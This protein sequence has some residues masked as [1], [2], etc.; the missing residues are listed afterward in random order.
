M[1]HE[2]RRVPDPFCLDRINECLRSGSRSIKLRP[3]AFAVLN[4]LIE[5]SGKLVTK[6]EL[7]STV[8]P[9]TF[10]S[11]AVLKVTIRQLRTAL[12]DDSNLPRFIET[13]HRRGYRFIGKIEEC[14]ESEMRD[15]RIAES[16]TS[17]GFS[18]EFVGR[19]HVLSRMESYLEKMLVG[20]R[21]IIFVTGEAGIGKTTLVDAFVRTVATHHQIQMARGQCLEHY[22][23]SEAYLPFLEAIGRLCREQPQVIDVLRTHAPMWLMQMP[24]LVGA[25][26]REALSREMTGATRERMLREIGDALQTLTAELRLVLIL[27][28]LHWSD[29]STLDLIAYLANQ[30]QSAHL[31]LIGTYRTV[32]LVLTGHPLKAVQRELRAKQQCHELPLEYLSKDDV[33]KYL[34]NRFPGN[35]FPAA[36]AALIHERTEGNPLFMVNVL[37]YLLAEGFVSETGDRWELTAKLEELEVGVP[38]NIRQM[39]MK[40]I[41]RLSMEDQQV[42]EAA[43]ISG[44]NFSALAIAS[45]L[46]QDVVEVEGRCEELAQRKC[47]LRERGIGEFPDGT[48]SARY[49]FIHALYVNT[50]YDRIPAARRSKLHKDMAERGEIIYGDHAGDIGTE[51]A[52]HF[53]QGHDYNR[54]VTYLKHAA[55]KAIHRFAYLEAV[56]L[57]RRGLDLLGKLPDNRER[58]QRELRLQLTLGV[59]L[60]ATTGYAAPEVGNVYRRARELCKQLD[61]PPDVSE[62]LW[63]LWTF[64]TLGADLGTARET[65]EELLSLAEHL[66]YPQLAMSGNWAMEITFTHLGEFALAIEHFEKALSLYDPKEYPDMASL[67]ALSPGV[68]MPC[69]AALSFWFLGQP[70]ASLA[71]IQ[72]ATTLARELGEPHSLAHAFLFSSFVHQLRREQRIAQ[73]HAEAVIAISIEHGLVMYRA[74]ATIMAGWSL[75]GEGQAEQAIE[76]IKEGLAALQATGTE[77]VRP[78]FL[79]LLAEALGVA[80]LPDE[81]LRVLDEAVELVDRTQEAYYLAELHRLKGELLLVQSSNLSGDTA[82]VAKAKECFH[83]A[84]RIARQQKAK[85][86]EL[87]ASMSLAR[88]YQQLGKREEARALLLQ[89]Y[90]RF[91]EGFE[92][93]DLRKAK[94]LLAELS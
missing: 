42:L 72:E 31:M 69:F 39:I 50:L 17:D 23:T 8:W 93:A 83:D 58:A 92:T 76:Q 74:M 18:H 14:G 45:A 27:E 32:E 44:M 79:A 4:Q 34:S 52:M 65:A 67:Y 38:E 57:A 30:R 6:E 70:D 22:G 40:Q 62:A 85:S 35:R 24:S 51:L 84:I 56:E 21:Q 19:N 26:E 2:T 7:L 68:A 75:I 13:A 87:R 10:V 11:D 90:D 36:L 46:G 59:P 53:E 5:N 9:E 81:G 47:F 12:N 61:D 41:A 37:D 77:L 33:V 82:A 43:S 1:D 63:G 25:S 49:G 3:K 66:P 89:I 48:V 54:A 80:S 60:V 15:Q 55:D 73:E 86:W 20:E 91:H 78:H 29:Y 88:L 28:D 71:R 64:H 16:V 94:T